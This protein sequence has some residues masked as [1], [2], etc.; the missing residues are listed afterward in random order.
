MKSQTFEAEGFTR[1]YWDFY[2]GFGI[3]ISVFLLLQAVVLWQLGSLAKTNT[4]GVRPM[5]VSFLAASIVN[6]GLGWTY[7]F[8][9]P[10]AMA[11]AIA[12]SLL[13]ALVLA[14]RKAAQPSVPADGS[15]PAS[16]AG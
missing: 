11:A 3:I 12:L 5:I 15:R 7:F 14:G 9:V 6:A 2:V 8:A 4:S 10:A 1:T 16:A 13:I